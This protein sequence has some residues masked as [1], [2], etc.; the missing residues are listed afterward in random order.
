MRKFWAVAALAVLGITSGASAQAERDSTDLAIDSLRQALVETKDRLEGMSENLATLNS[1]VGIL[2]YVKIS[3]YLQTRWEYIDTL[4][5]FT[6]GPDLKQNNGASNIYIRRGRIKFTVTPNSTSKYVIYFDAS[7]NSVSLKEAYVELSKTANFH[8]V[9]LTVGQFNWPFGYEIEYSSSQRDFPERSAAEN[10]L[11]KGERDRGINLTYTAPKY[12]SANLGVFQGFGIDDKTFTWWDPTKQKDIIARAKA[13]LGML[14]I[15]VSGYWGDNFIPGTAAVAA[16]TAW[17]DTDGD[18]VV[19]STEVKNTAAKAAVPGFAKDK[20]RYGADAQLYLDFLPIGGTAIRGEYYWGEDYDKSD[21]TDSLVSR[22]GWYLWVSQS[23]STKLGAALRY[24]YWDPN[25]ETAVNDAFG[26]WSFALHYFFD[27]NVRI[28]AAY[29]MPGKLAG[30][31][32]FSRV[33]NGPE[34]NRFTLQFQ[35]AF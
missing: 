29:D 34:L 6:S 8:T 9:A 33:E 15:G 14:D 16:S 18:H 35:F 12:F 27:P 19:D 32:T 25:S 4:P 1:D 28:T 30:E 2:K 17:T 13:K 23:I 5:N 10:A 21:V 3:G 24:D 31:S 22:Q 7:K 26:T 11:F 20:N